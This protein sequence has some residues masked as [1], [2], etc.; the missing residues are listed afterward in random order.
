MVTRIQRALQISRRRRKDSH[1][2]YPNLH[3][4]HNIVPGAS[5][6]VSTNFPET[7]RPVTFKLRGNRT[8]DTAAGN[9]LTMGNEGT[10]GMAAG[11]LEVVTGGGVTD[12][13]VGTYIGAPR[14]HAEI[15]VAINPAAGLVMAWIDSQRVIAGLVTTFPFSWATTG[16]VLYTA[17]AG[18]ATISNLDVFIGAVPRHAIFISGVA[19]PITDETLLRAARATYQTGH[20]PFLDDPDL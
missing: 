15:V 14:D 6:P 12:T 17:P 2:G 3:Q 8:S 5:L 1:R 4:T 11:N 18:L 16:N 19:P 20:W 10:I 7:D 13:F 9:I